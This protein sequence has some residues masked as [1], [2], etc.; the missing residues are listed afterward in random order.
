MAPYTGLQECNGIFKDSVCAH[1]NP[2]RFIKNICRPG[3]GRHRDAFPLIKLYQSGQGVQMTPFF[4]T[5]G[6]GGGFWTRPHM[7]TRTI[8]MLDRVS[9][10]PEYTQSDP[11]VAPKWPKSGSARSV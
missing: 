1:P 6:K 2:T 3:Q 9:S 11:K 5:S 10:S 8:Y 4:L 7:K